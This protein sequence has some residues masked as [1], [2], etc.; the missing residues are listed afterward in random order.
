M[1]NPIVL[2]GL[3]IVVFGAAIWAFRPP[4]GAGKSIIKFSAFELTLDVPALGVMALGVVLVLIGTTLQTVPSP[5]PAP[6]GS[7]AA[8]QRWQDAKIVPAERMQQAQ[9][10]ESS[11]KTIPPNAFEVGYENDS[12]LFLCRAHYDDGVYP[13]KTVNGSCNI[14]VNNEEIIKSQYEVL[15]V[16]KES[17]MWVSVLNS[18]ITY[19]TRLF[20]AGTSRGEDIPICRGEFQGGLHP[21]VPSNDNCIISWGGATRPIPLQS[22]LSISER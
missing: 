3:L 5:A 20:G 9:W 21:G 8:E 4:A 19:G 14:P 17:L 2:V 13:G 11:S 15:I 10:M 12:P 7:S 22:L 6:N 16:Q 18:R 1:T